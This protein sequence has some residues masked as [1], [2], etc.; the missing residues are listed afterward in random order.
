MLLAAYAPPLT[1]LSLSSLLAGTLVWRLSYLQLDCIC[2][3]C[4]LARRPPVLTWREA[5]T[6]VLRRREDDGTFVVMMQSVEHP[7]APAREPPFYNWR[8]PIRAQVTRASHGRPQSIQKP[9]QPA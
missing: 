6:V 7:A 1:C 3:V 2:F 5:L 8:A 4:C 9:S